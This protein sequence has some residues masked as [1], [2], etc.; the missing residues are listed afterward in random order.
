MLSNQRKDPPANQR[1]SNKSIYY[2][3][4]VERCITYA[5]LQP[6]FMALTMFFNTISNEKNN[7]WSKEK[8]EDYNALLTAI[9]YISCGLGAFIQGSFVDFN[10]KHVY[11]I[12]KLLLALTAIPFVFGDIYVMEFS[13]F[14]QGM[15]GEICH[16][17]VMWTSYQIA[18]PRHREVFISSFY[19][20]NLGITVLY[21]F[22]SLYDDGGTVYWRLMFLA[23]SAIL[24]ATIVLD[25]TVCKNINTFTYYLRN[26]GVDRTV[27]IVSTYY[28][29]TTA[30]Y[31]TNRFNNLFELQGEKRTL[32]GVEGE[33]L[34]LQ[35]SQ[36]AG[37]RGDNTGNDYQNGDQ[38]KKIDYWR[39]P[40]KF[41]QAVKDFKVETFHVFI[42]AACAML[43][44][45]ESFGQFAVLYGAKDL[46]DLEAVK[47]TKEYVF[48]SYFLG[49]AVAL[50][51]AVFKLN[52]RRKLAMLVS[53]GIVVTCFLSVNLAYFL[54]DLRIARV[55]ILPAEGLHAGIYATLYI[56]GN[57]VCPPEVVA[58]VGLTKRV[59]A[60]LLGYVIPKVVHFE[61]LH[62]QGLAR[63][64]LWFSAIAIGSHI[65]LWLVMI[66]THSVSKENVYR[67]MRGK[68]LRKDREETTLDEIQ[69]ELVEMDKRF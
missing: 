63:R 66:E 59:T 49:T 38:Q 27:E 50:A 56:Y 58:I 51:I 23:P 61:T 41:I 8:R 28:D 43:S 44:M 31:L 25:Y 21:S 68:R 35:A 45:L 20:C 1:L 67:M 46:R 64:M 3:G 16:V 17:I 19:V 6:P 12:S 30:R 39:G 10:T 15:F 60:G 36:N 11:N 40:R 55:A 57:D 4:L 48:W 2:M 22:L 52:T 5:A 62:F 32:E 54:E 53:H 34:E 26:F 7:N 37:E 9:F 33:R 18:L 65:A 29:D 14:L 42:I 69:V 47:L 13:R 24:V